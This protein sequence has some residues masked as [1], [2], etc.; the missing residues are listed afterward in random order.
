MVTQGSENRVISCSNNH[1]N[2]EGSAWC[3]ICGLPIINFDGE[4]ELLLR[5]LAEGS[6]ILDLPRKTC[7]WESEI[8]AANSSMASTNPGVR[9]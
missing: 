6:G 2:P 8:R 5:T 3:A 9:V 4:L 1:Q 7:S